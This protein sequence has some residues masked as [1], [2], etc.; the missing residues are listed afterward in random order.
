M[1][2][3]LEPQFWSLQDW[4]GVHRLLYFQSVLCQQPP[5]KETKATTKFR[6]SFQYQT[7][8]HVSMSDTQRQNCLQHICT[9]TSEAPRDNSKQWYTNTQKPNSNCRIHLTLQAFSTLQ[10]LQITQDECGCIFLLSQHTCEARAERC[11][12]SLQSA[13]TICNSIS[14]WRNK[15]SLES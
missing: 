10:L 3:G 8:K 14:K 6:E 11:I 4:S 15:L 12:M 2:M 9:K 13:C 1:W 5:R 7:S